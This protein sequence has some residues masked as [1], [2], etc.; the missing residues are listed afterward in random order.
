MTHLVKAFLADRA[1][2]PFTDRV[3]LRG[4]HGR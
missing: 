1:D 3:G 4:S 2:D